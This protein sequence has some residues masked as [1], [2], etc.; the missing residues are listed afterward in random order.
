MA[1]ER[2]PGAEEIGWCQGCGT[3]QRG[4]AAR[5]SQDYW[6]IGISAWVCAVCRDEPWDWGVRRIRPQEPMWCPCAGE[7]ADQQVASGDGCPEEQLDSSVIESL[8]P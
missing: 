7:H 6:D 4:S 8:Q 1:S 2:R 3:W 5:L